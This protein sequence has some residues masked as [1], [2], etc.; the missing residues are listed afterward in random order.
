MRGSLPHPTD[1]SPV[2]PERPI[3]PLPKRRIR[4]R[5]SIEDVGSIVF[6]PVP[7]SSSPLFGSPNNHSERSFNYGN[8]DS[9]QDEHDL[10]HVCDCG[11]HHSG[12]ESDEDEEFHERLA[13]RNSW[14]G[15]T[16]GR[17]MRYSREYTNSLAVRTQP[18]P[19]RSTAS[20]ADGY[21]SFENT[22]NKKKRKIP[23]SGTSGAGSGSDGM[24]IP[25]QS[26]DVSVSQDGQMSNHYYHSSGSGV[27]ISGAGR[28]RNS[29]AAIR[30]LAERRPLVSTTNGSNAVPTGRSSC[31]LPPYKHTNSLQPL[32]P[33]N[34][35]LFQP[36]LPVLRTIKGFRL[37][38]KKTLAFSNVNS[39]LPLF[40]KTSHLSGLQILGARWACLFAAHCRRLHNPLLI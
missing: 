5:L 16:S 2:Y 28:G 9:L 22:N 33:T 36:L 12:G 1:S 11:G 21:E 37:S 14:P 23:I 32:L 40:P 35:V 30:P 6:P 24:G 18:P 13:H 15:H 26:V 8:V 31:C 10:D 20:S 27:G 7:P 38:D 39:T 4:S 25:T 34:K 29:K 17:T 3:R 19:A